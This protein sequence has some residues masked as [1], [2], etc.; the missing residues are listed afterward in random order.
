MTKDQQAK[1]LLD[2]AN[3]LNTKLAEDGVLMDL[4][5]VSSNLHFHL[6]G[7]TFAAVARITKEKVEASYQSGA[8]HG[9][10]KIGVV[11]FAVCENLL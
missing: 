7:A 3:D 4:Y 2:I 8:L 11:E 10:I 6:D 9:V 5:G 1:V